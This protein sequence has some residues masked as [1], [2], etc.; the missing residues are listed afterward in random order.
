MLN[1]ELME[2]KGTLKYKWKQNKTRHFC[3][4][5]DLPLRWP[6]VKVK[7]FF[8][9]LEES[10]SDLS[11]SIGFFFQISA[12]WQSCYSND[13]FLLLTPFVFSSLYN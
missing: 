5:S 3:G 13:S 6:L 2:I 12:G 8:F 10:K 9:F 11:G 1:A 7:S 4:L